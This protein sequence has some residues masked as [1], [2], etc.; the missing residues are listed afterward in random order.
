MAISLI[1]FIL[2]LFRSP[3]SAA[4]FIADPDGSLRDAGLPN[5][6]AAQLHAV[7][8][9]AA[10]AGVLLGGG[11]PVVGLQRAVADH[12]SIPASFGNQVASPFSP[13]T[14]V[15]SNNTTDWA[16]H[17]DTD[18]AS[19]NHTPIM[20]PNQDAGA[21]AQQGA[22]NLG[23][24]DIT[25]GDKSTNTATNGGVVVD[26]DNDGDIVSGDGAVLGDGNTM[27]NGDIWAGAG[28]N[29]AV[30]KDNDIE[31]N[32]QTAGGDLISDNEGPV[33]SDV[34]MSGGH[35]GGASGGDSLIGIGSGGAS[36]GDGGNAGSIILTDA[37]TTAVGGNQ[38]SVDGDYGSDNTQD[39]SVSTSV[40]T[41]THSSVE[42]NSSS[43]ESNIAS[44]N[45]TALGSGNETNTALA[46]GNSYDTSSAFGSGN[47]YDGSSAF[48]SGNSFESQ[49]D[50]DVASSNSTNTGFD[51]F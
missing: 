26:G 17:N 25:L 22:F 6:T 1:D 42:D 46:S 5:V 30:G 18:F 13:Q 44:G 21:N 2:D 7:A 37:S 35:G 45:E 27:N 10:P 41:E 23:F 34:D 4:S 48:G 12:H 8:A 50:T 33:I 19:N 3:A 49:S 43:Y 31:D 16:S 47:S 9:T 38:T 39:N 32:S 51:A 28:S 36:G 14:Q 29:V 40:E 11:N 15:A 24:G 20:S